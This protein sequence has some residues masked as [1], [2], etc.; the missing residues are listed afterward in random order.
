M[1]CPEIYVIIAS[2]Q[3]YKSGEVIV[4]DNKTLDKLIVFKDKKLTKEDVDFA[5]SCLSDQEPLVRMEAVGLICSSSFFNEEDIERLLPL[6]D[7]DEMMV[8]TE[9]YDWLSSVANAT[10]TEKL[11]NAIYSDKDVIGCSYA[12]ETWT[13]AIVQNAPS[14]YSFNEETDF[15]KSIQN[16]DFILKSEYTRL[17]C[18]YALYSFKVKGALQN[19]LSFLNSEDYHIQCSVVNDL[20]RIVRK[21]DITEVN[22]V[23]SELLNKHPCK[24]VSSLIKDFLNQSVSENSESVQ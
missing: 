12:V 23:L 17:A 2:V 8:R 5:R 14:N 21:D 18:E 20:M 13:D 16:C 3:K 11:K 19:I 1:N 7:D 10:I 6:F 15:I 4:S 9:V 22:G 24:A